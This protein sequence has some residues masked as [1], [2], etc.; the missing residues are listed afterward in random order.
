MRGGSAQP[1]QDVGS[2]R[3]SKM[4]APP[5]NRLRP[6]SNGR[7]AI[8]RR[9]TR[10]PKKTGVYWR[11][12]V[13]AVSVV[14]LSVLALVLA[15]S[16]QVPGATDRVLPIDPENAGPDVVLA[17]VAGI[18]ISSPIRP[19]DLTGLAYHPEGESL[20]EM[21]PWGRNL[22]GNPLL[23][24]FASVF[25]SDSTPEKIQYYLMDPADR[26]GPRTGALDVGAE[27]GTPVYSPVTGT[28]VAIRPDP[29]LQEGANVVEIQPVDNPDV[30]VSV[31]L[32]QQIDEEVG[33]RS[34]VE[35]GMTE[36]G[37]VA[38]SAKVLRPQLASYASGSGNH[39]T[40]SVSR[41]N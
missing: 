8:D 30:R 6:T 16:A 13:L 22:S 17:E 10:K 9:R 7:D 26:R 18:Y 4:K 20:V 36:I 39:V 5:S 38:D 21:S 40:V 33:P 2:E 23:R 31:S 35:A 11:R 28:I 41:V 32:V 14:L 19:E 3:P 12:R 37:S 1:A 34:P 27:A 25:A 29:V 15:A 24:L